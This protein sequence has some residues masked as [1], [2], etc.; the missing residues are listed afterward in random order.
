LFSMTAM[1]RSVAPTEPRHTFGILVAF[2]FVAMLLTV[3]FGQDPSE[4]GLEKQRITRTCMQWHV[5]ASTVVSRLLQSTRDSDLLQ[6]SDS[7][8]RMRRARR[9][10]ETGWVTLACQDYH[11]VAA[12]IPGYAMTNQLF[13]CSRIASFP[14]ERD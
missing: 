13:P 6:V 14:Y 9:N 8:F 10:C 11:A 7:V 3:L 12:S 4:A 1:N 5:A 2:A